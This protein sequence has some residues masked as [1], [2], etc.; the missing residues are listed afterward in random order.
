MGKSVG[1][2]NDRALRA[3]CIEKVFSKLSIGAGK[4]G[5]EEYIRLLDYVYQ[6]VSGE[7]EI[8][9]SCDGTVSDL[10]KEATIA[11]AKLARKTHYEKFHEEVDKAVDTLK[12]AMGDET[13]RMYLAAI[14]RKFKF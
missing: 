3:W 11:A 8:S 1:F 5:M 7:K 4:H 10:L 9:T 6:F 13:A 14:V 12:R 2:H